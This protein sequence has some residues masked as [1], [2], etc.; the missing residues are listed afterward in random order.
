MDSAICLAWQ[1]SNV[2]LGWFG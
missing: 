2:A 1:S